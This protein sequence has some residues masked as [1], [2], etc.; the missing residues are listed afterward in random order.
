MWQD[1]GTVRPM[2]YQQEAGEPEGRNVGRAV[3]QD[4]YL[5]EA[6]AE[7][8]HHI[9]GLILGISDVRIEQLPMRLQHHTDRKSVV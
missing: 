3:L 4:L 6:L 8:Q 5:I 9:E 2:G 7:L 1:V